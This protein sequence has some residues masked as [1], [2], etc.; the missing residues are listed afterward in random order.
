MAKQRISIRLSE[1]DIKLLGL[2]ND[3]SINGAIEDVID[4]KKQ[5]LI[6][7]AVKQVG[8]YKK[9]LELIEKG[10]LEFEDNTQE[11]EYMLCNG[12]IIYRCR[13]KGPDQLWSKWY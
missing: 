9:A 6:N 13:I 12:E 3:K 11:W 1:E 2:I 10:F 8:D 7:D 4:Y 5:E